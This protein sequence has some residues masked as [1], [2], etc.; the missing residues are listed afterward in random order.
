MLIY[1]VYCVYLSFAEAHEKTT[2]TEKKNEKK[3]N[4]PMYKL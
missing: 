1:Y 4:T 3:K 2:T